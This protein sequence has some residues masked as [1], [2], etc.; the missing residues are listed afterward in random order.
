[1][2]VDE[3]CVAGFANLAQA[4]HEHGAKLVVQLFHPGREM[5]ESF[6]GS[7][8]VAYAPSVSPSERY[9]VIPRAMTVSLIKEVI[10]GYGRAAQL[11]EQAGVDGVEVV[12]SHGYLP[13][14]FLNPCVNRREDDY[15]G[16]PE[17]RMRFVKEVVQTIREFT[18]KNFAIGLRISGDEKHDEGLPEDI[19]LSTIM[20]LADQLDYVSVVAGTSATLGGA[21]HIA[22]PM[23]QE[24]GYVA[25]FAAQVKSKVSIPVIVT[26]R[27]NQPHTAET[28]IASGQADMCGMTRAM[29][30]DPKLPLKAEMGLTDDIRACIGC[31]QACIGHFHK[32]HAIS[33]IQHPETGRELEYGTMTKANLPQKLMVIGGGVGGMKAA[34]TAAARGHSVTL[35]EADNQLGGQARL[36]QLLPNR[37]EFGGI[38]T[39][40]AREIERAGVTVKLNTR[41]D[42]DLIKQDAPNAIILATGSTPRWPDRFDYDGE[43]QVVDATAVLRNEVNIGSSV[44]IA[45]WTCDWVGMGMAEFLAEKGCSVT[46]AVNGIAAGEQLQSYVR[47]SNI[48]RLNDL[49]VK[50]IPYARLYGRDEDTVYFQHTANNTPIILENTET[51]V[52]A[53][54][55]TPNTSLL[56]V[57]DGFEGKVISIGDCVM[58]RTCEEA[59]LEGMRAGWAL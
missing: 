28:I 26:G 6:D 24:N 29:I 39:N 37:S 40:L 41:V 2:G 46:L 23:Y 49:G 19:S 57:L 5:T 52:L 4:V 50:I 53:Q 51:L 21:I 44:V 10:Q 22:P 14:Q 18:Q 3:S 16:N 20:A 59:V 43:G 32:G 36:A 54:G 35:Y 48:G 34:A 42:I 55:N 45:D 33:C 30:C 13:S 38:I 58:P 12:A 56:D 15:G 17:K 9:H 7:A 27:I 47:D 11:L 8:P 31:N 1:M 25:P